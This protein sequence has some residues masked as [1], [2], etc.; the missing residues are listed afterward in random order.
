MKISFSPP[1]MTEL[2]A[3][4]ASEAIRSGWITTGPKTKEFE[5]QITEYCHVNKAVCLNSQTACAEMALRLLGIGAE[6]GGSSF[7]EVIVPAYTYTATASIV[8]HVGAKLVLIDSQTDSLEMD[9]EALENAINEHTKAIIPVDLGGIPCD[10]D[11]IFAIVENKKYLFKATSAVQ[12]AIG[13]VAICTDAAHAFGASWHG[14]MVGSIADFSSFSFHAVKN[15]TT[16]EGGA[17][18]WNIPKIDDDELYHQAQLY[19]LHGQSK[20][21]L[22][23]TQLGAWEYDIIGPWY[24]CN[25]TDIMAAIGMAQLAR[26][27]GILERRK[28]IIGRYDAEFRKLG[29]QVLPHYTDEHQSS[30]HLYITR[31]PGVELEQRQEII[32]KMAEAGIATNVHYKPLPMMTAYKN[33]GF[34][35]KDYPN[36]YKQFENEITLPL[37]TRLSDEEVEYVIE[38]YSEIVKRYV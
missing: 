34:D 33:L 2:E 14:K 32:V 4:G 36:A 13:R 15:L 35:I 38:K 25:M 19:S 16:A 12:E 10:Y 29:V 20:D 31:I 9:Y 3:Q 37:H 21:A 18:T 7:D 5:R 26:Y 1:D 11:R 8:C 27:E 22:A 28:E 30:G 17:L 6:N 23:K 24:K